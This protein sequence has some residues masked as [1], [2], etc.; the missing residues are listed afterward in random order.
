MC[1]TYV[2]RGAL[3]WMDPADDIPKS[4]ALGRPPAIHLS[5][6]DCE[7]P[8]DEDASL[9]GEGAEAQT[10]CGYFANVTFVCVLMERGG[11]S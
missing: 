9:S 7:F 6:V 11:A 4:L 3:D 8:V 5:Y 2:V 10:G 1:P